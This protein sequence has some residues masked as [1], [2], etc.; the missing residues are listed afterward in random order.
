MTPEKIEK[1]M[2]LL[3]LR[4]SLETKLKALTALDT[5]NL[6]ASLRDRDSC[7]AVILDDGRLTWLLE[8]EIGL[9]QVK[10][11]DVQKTIDEL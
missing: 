7:S 9:T 6:R 5:K 10:L 1:L 8:S 4:E 11:D 3:K 2:S